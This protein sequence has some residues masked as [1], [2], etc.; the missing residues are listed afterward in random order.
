MDAIDAEALD[1]ITLFDNPRTVDFSQFK[2]RGP[3]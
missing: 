2:P 3:L 1:C